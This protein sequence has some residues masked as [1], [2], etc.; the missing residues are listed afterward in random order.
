MGKID[1]EIVKFI[2][3]VELDP[4]TAA[5]YTKGLQ[6]AEKHNAALRKSIS[7]TVQKMDELKAA[8]Q[9]NS[10]E[11][12]RHKAS[13]EADTKALKESSKQ[14]EKYSSALGIQSMNYNQLQKHAKQVRAALNSVHKEANPQLWEKYNKELIATQKRMS[15]LKGGADKTKGVLGGMF[16]KIIPT[17][18]VVQLGLKAVNGLVNLGK[19]AWEDFKNETQKWGDAIRVEMAAV[20]A[21]WH[22]F[23][24]NLSAGREEITLSYNEV[25]KLAREAAKL[26]DEIFELTNSYKI[27]EAEAKPRMQE[28][29]A[30]FRDTSRPIEERKEALEEMKQLELQLAEDRLLI[31]KQEED[32]AYD[33]FRIQIS[34]TENILYMSGN[35][36]LIALE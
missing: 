25:A 18:D 2:A 11:F 17:F 8:G 31:A 7:E 5:E 6:E 26:K 13:L 22:H 1:N 36:R 19:K 35:N 24:R 28:L 30:V 15:E 9:E 33:H 12:Q 20:D 3:E 23:I 10:A 34:F 32:A 16:K 4:Q 14:A 29:E 27:L 21:V